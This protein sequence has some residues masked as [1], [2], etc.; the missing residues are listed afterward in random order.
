MPASRRNA[1]RALALLVCGI[2]MS[3]CGSTGSG[4]SATTS[5]SLTVLPSPTAGPTHA[6]PSP[7]KLTLASPLNDE[8]ISGTT[9]HVTVTVTGGTITSQYSQHVSATVGHIHLYMNSQLVSM[10]YATSTDLPIEAGAEY[11]L[12][13]EWVAEDHGSFTPRDVTPKIY[14]TVLG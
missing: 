8:I 7:V 5:F 4:S 14:F 3:A 11:S 6:E 1:R 13:A 2:A 12:Y 10:A 9:V